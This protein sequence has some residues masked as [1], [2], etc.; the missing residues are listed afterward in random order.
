MATL[1]G[2]HRGEEG[3][4]YGHRADVVDQHNLQVDVDWSAENFRP[5]TDPAVVDENVYGLV[6]VQYLFDLL[7]DAVQ[8]GQVQ[9]NDD[10]GVCG[11][12]L[13]LNRRDER[14]NSNEDK[15]YSVGLQQIPSHSFQFITSSGSQDHSAAG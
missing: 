7:R 4:R 8:V 10:W 15:T 9:G 5:D 14:N 11:N 3:F 2:D 1:P 13:E 6:N 12:G